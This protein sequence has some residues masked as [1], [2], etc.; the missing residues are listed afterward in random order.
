MSGSDAR[1]ACRRVKGVARGR[2]RSRAAR[3]LAARRF[4]VLVVV[5]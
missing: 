3:G 4:D 5:F 2:A 1:H